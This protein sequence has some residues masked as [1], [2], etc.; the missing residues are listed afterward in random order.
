MEKMVLSATARCNGS[1]YTC[2]LSVPTPSCVS[3]K[4]LTVFSPNY[5]NQPEVRKA[6]GVSSERTFESCNMQVNQAFQFQGDVSHNTAAL[7]PPLLEDG[8]RVLI[9]AGDADFM[10]RLSI[11]CSP[12]DKR[13]RG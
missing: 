13:E 10:V 4:R 9:Y 7:I 1:R 3:K 11:Y 5:R 6:L 8:I 12:L 2:E